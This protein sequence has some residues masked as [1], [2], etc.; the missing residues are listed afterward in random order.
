MS[1]R[2]PQLPRG[3]GFPHGR[4][5]PFLS[6]CFPWKAPLRPAPPMPR[7]ERLPA[8]PR[9]RFFKGQGHEP[10]IPAF[11]RAGITV[12]GDKVSIDGGQPAG[13]NVAPGHHCFS[14]AF[15]ISGHGGHSLVSFIKGLRQHRTGRPRGKGIPPAVEI[16]QENPV[17]AA[18]VRAT[19]TDIS[20]G[21]FPSPYHTTTSAPPSIMQRAGSGSASSPHTAPYSFR[22]VYP[23][24]QNLPPETCRDTIGGKD[25]GFPPL[26]RRTVQDGDHTASRRKP[27]SFSAARCSL[28]PPWEGD[29]QPV[30]LVRRPHKKTGRLFE[31]FL[32]AGSSKP[33]QGGKNLVIGS[34]Q[35]VELGAVGS[36]GNRVRRENGIEFRVSVL[37]IG[38][39]GASRPASA[40]R[41]LP[42]M[43]QGT[44]RHFP[45]VDQAA[46]AAVQHG[47]SLE[48]HLVGHGDP[49]RFLR[50]PGGQ[51]V[52]ELG[53]D[54][55]IP[56]SSRGSQV[57]RSRIIFAPF[58]AR[59][60]LISGIRP[61]AHTIMPT[62]PNSVSATG[63]ELPGR[64]YRPSKC[65][66]FDLKVRS[67]SRRRSP[68]IARCT[69]HPFPAERALPRVNSRS[70]ATP[71]KSAR[72]SAFR[73]DAAVFSPPPR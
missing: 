23:G 12:S 71:E 51:H 8:G 16:Q 54:R 20:R 32:H 55:V 13:N 26:P 70:A 31:I 43:N 37:G 64:T 9:A 17:L 2:P 15:P 46:A 66:R 57:V 41:T 19:L 61:S 65:Q 67:S 25:D 48:A 45:G 22:Q 52:L 36:G 39:R 27:D 47:F 5:D 4:S 73:H 56:V 28:P 40:T 33:A 49:P 7:W 53:L 69:G 24:A 35:G 50:R 38:G 72:G 1:P 44:Q 3:P 34:G 62:G 42:P 11:M 30:A 14:A 21:R 60:R 59:I 29:R 58:R 68:E 6:G 63:K 10:F 18:L